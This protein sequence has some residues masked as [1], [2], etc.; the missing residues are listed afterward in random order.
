MAERTFHHLTAQHGHT[1]TPEADCIVTTGS[2]SV[3]TTAQAGVQACLVAS[4]PAIYTITS[5]CRI[6]ETFKGASVA[7]PG[8]GNKIT[9]DN[10]FLVG[11]EASAL[12]INTAN[13]ITA[14]RGSGRSIATDAACA[15]P[16]PK[17]TAGVEAV[18]GN[19]S[20]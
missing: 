16:I 7:V 4:E 8:G 5:S 2:G 10:D 12:D 9:V 20:L 15:Y 1:A 11:W 17:N 3:I 19:L 14:R 6:T 18:V 13:R